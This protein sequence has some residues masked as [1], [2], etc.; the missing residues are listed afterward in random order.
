MK[1]DVT[2]LA[3]MSDNELARVGDQFLEQIIAEGMTDVAM[4]N[5]A[6]MLHQMS[7]SAAMWRPSRPAERPR[8]VSRR[9]DNVVHVDFRSPVTPMRRPCTSKAARNP[10]LPPLQITSST[11]R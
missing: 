1:I 6:R 8:V 10:N 4:Q 7:L 11:R 2:A 3:R 5:L 9:A